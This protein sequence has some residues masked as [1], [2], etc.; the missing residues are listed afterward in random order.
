MSAQFLLDRQHLV[1]VLSDEKGNISIFAYMP[2]SL[3]SRGGENLVLLGSLNIGSPANGILRINGK[4][5]FLL[6][7]TQFLGHA[8]GPFLEATDTIQEIQ[9]NILCTLSGSW[10]VL[11]PINERVFRRLQILQ[12]L[13]TTQVPQ[14]AGLNPKACRASKSQKLLQQPKTTNKAIIDGNFVFQFMNLSTSTKNELARA[15]GSNR[16]QIMDDITEF[17]RASTHY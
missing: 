12:Q 17:R 4:R 3:E 9:T 15:S 8:K 16:Y 14:A 2:E 5:H 6:D 13:M 11:R 1:F 7:L 10:A